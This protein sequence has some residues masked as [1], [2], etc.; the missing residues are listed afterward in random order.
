[1]VAGDG[2]G[3][4]AQCVSR[5]RETTTARLQDAMKRVSLELTGPEAM[6]LCGGET[7]ALQPMSPMSGAG[8]KKKSVSLRLPRSA[9]SSASAPSQGAGRRPSM[10][11]VSTASTAAG[12]TAYPSTSSC[13]RL[14]SPEVG[15]G[16][17]ADQIEELLIQNASLKKSLAM[18]QKSVVESMKG[19]KA[20]F[21]GNGIFRTRSA[22][23]GGYE[24]ADKRAGPQASGAAAA[25][26][27]NGFVDQDALRA[28]L[29]ARKSQLRQAQLDCEE[30]RSEAA[31]WQEECQRL[32]VECQEA[33]G[34]LEEAACREAGLVKRL[35]TAEDAGREQAA[36]AES[37]RAE[38]EALRQRVAQVT[39][40][41]SE[42][43]QNNVQASERIRSLDALLSEE[44]QQR[45][46]AE[47]QAAERLSEEVAL[48][49]RLEQEL[50]AMKN[51]A[52]A[53]K[54]RLEQLSQDRLQRARRTLAAAF[55][56]ERQ[57]LRLCFS[58]WR[59]WCQAEREQRLQERARTL[60]SD[61]GRLSHEAA[62][63]ESA[64]LA[65]QDAASKASDEA[66][67]HA[68]AAD[69]QREG[70]TVAEDLCK[71]AT[72]ESSRWQVE[73]A[74]STSRAALLEAEVH[75]LR[76][77]VELLRKKTA[78]H[79]EGVDV[80][81]LESRIKCLQE[82]LAAALK[83]T[84]VATSQLET[85]Q[86]ARKQDAQAADER[87]KEAAKKE[88]TLQGELEAARAATGA[89]KSAVQAAADGRDQAQKLAQE[90]SA[91]MKAL[92]AELKE[93]KATAERLAKE[94]KEANKKADHSASVTAKQ[95]DTEAE[96]KRLADELAK[97][98]QANPA[99]DELQQKVATLKADLED[100]R[101]S[102]AV[103]K[104]DSGSSGQRFEALVQEAEQLRQDKAALGK[105]VAEAKAA[106]K[107]A[108]DSR[109]A[110]GGDKLAAQIKQALEEA[111]RSIRVMV[112]APKVA[113]NVGGHEAEINMSFPVTKIRDS[114]QKEVLPKFAR[115]FAIGD[116]TGDGEIRR[117]VQE[118][119]EQL[120]VTLQSKIQELLPQAE[121]TCNWDGFGAK[122]G[123]LATGRRA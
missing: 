44:R 93:A 48:R 86:R 111:R 97:H 51:S 118:M 47:Q 123:S 28:A 100:A 116:D 104:S 10:E 24:V 41:L 72:A 27:L 78:P 94:L 87:A 92:A 98:K 55:G 31:S 52:S 25:D 73:A 107:A 15:G 23:T 12:D 105:A 11:E 61:V 67:S 69:E 40:E 99:A 103:A 108:E 110:L 65:A 1:M 63:A 106:Q 120:A 79:A 35:R 119:V 42:A 38:I 71:S 59:S 21:Q 80:K 60:E 68:R 34:K 82:E 117:S 70:R 5:R 56:G 84:G 32:K 22:A 85:E 122:T 88:N 16:S 113:I 49:S 83:Q 53:S 64:K 13:S 9:S 30:A 36:E 18:L 74:E 17:A 19:N 6:S 115:V 39:S 37:L 112:T 114:V 89:A 90:V 2:A 109:E 7:Q 66:R 33:S 62:V 14:C 29:E 43:E 50:E 91:K 95:A 54:E 57:W 121:G 81:D 96:R 75:Q 58:A 26:N 3:A 8:N 102:L 4:A 45:R 76:Q 101:T 20:Q 46:S 77:E